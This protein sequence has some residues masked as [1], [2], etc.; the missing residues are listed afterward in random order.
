[1]GARVWHDGIKFTRCHRKMFEI[2]SPDT[3]YRYA[4]GSRIPDHHIV[5]FNLQCICISEADRGVKP[6][7]GYTYWRDLSAYEASKH[8]SGPWGGKWYRKPT[9]IT[10]HSKTNMAYGPVFTALPTWDRLSQKRTRIYIGLS[11]HTYS[12]SIPK[13]TE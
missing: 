2:Q 10:G 7:K 4:D 13:G 9:P 8:I 5:F 6:H 1:M 3:D 12:G 11:G